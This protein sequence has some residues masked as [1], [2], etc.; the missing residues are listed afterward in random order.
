MK[1]PKTSYSIYA[2]S[3]LAVLICLLLC[4]EQT[5]VA[6][7][8]SPEDE[9]CI[10]CHVSQFNSGLQQKY[11]HSP[12]FERQCS[13]CHLAGARSMAAAESDFLTGSLVNQEIVWGK[14]KRIAEERP[15]SEHLLSLAGLES[16]NSYRFRIITGVQPELSDF[17]SSWYGLRPTELKATSSVF[18][19]EGLGGTGISG[20]TVAWVGN[21]ALISWQ[22]SEPLFG[23]VELQLLEGDLTTAETTAQNDIVHPLLRDP[24]DLAINACYQCHP[25][26]TLGTSHPVRLYGGLDVR[27]PQELPTVEGMMTCV[28]CH[29]P[30][31]SAGKML[32]RETI[33]TKL[34]VACHVKYKNSS[35]STMFR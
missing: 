11:V 5:L 18:V 22:T 33:K 29:D 7:L 23:A 25:E 17:T 14:V 10:R 12:F 27:I 2:L 34:C 13:S 28:T 24:E 32:V 1:A 35:P 26:S 3:L 20:L 21:V 15:V 16:D 19:T 8:V 31:G 30:H 4:G 6:Q 9:Q